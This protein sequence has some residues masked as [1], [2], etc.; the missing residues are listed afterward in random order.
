L[1]ADDSSDQALF[2]VS[3]GVYVAAMIT[4]HIALLYRHE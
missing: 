1:K 4:G 2:V 3:L